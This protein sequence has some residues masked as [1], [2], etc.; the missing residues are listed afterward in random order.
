MCMKKKDECQAYQTDY[1]SGTS[2][3]SKETCTIFKWQSV[4]ITTSC[5]GMLFVHIYFF[6]LINIRL[7]I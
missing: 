3:S 2:S 4:E 6:L 5:I 1:L 7:T